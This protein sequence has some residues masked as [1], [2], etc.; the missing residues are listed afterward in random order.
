MRDHLEAVAA[1]GEGCG[2]TAWCAGVIQVHSWLLS[3]FSGP[4]QDDVYGETSDA[5]IA[6]VIGLG[7][8]S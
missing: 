6:A 1:L 7:P 3:H 8:R 4:A 2:S 5:S